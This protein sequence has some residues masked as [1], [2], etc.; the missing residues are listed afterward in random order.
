MLRAAGPLGAFAKIKK[1]VGLQVQV[2]R[3][4]KGSSLNL[5]FLGGWG[6][7]GLLCRRVPCYIG[8]LKM[9]PSLENCP[10]SVRNP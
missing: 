9:D 6:G 7:G 10:E 1:V 5:G 8:D 3:I 2:I 4:H